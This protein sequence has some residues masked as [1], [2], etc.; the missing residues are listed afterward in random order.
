MRYNFI[1]RFF[2][3][4]ARSIHD[5]I[6]PSSTLTKLTAAELSLVFH[7]VHHSH[8]YISQS[9]TTDLLKK[10]FSES[11]IGQNI[12]CGKTKARDLAVNVLGKKISYAAH[13]ETHISYDMF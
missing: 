13:A 4:L 12:T 2:S 5:F 9:C 11:H 10:I 8:S 6:P 7:G 3:H 1:N